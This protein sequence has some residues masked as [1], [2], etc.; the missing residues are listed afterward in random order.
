[1]GGLIIEEDTHDEEIS[2]GTSSV[3]GARR[4]SG[5]S[6]L[7]FLV[8]LPDFYLLFIV[9]AKKPSIFILYIVTNCA[10]SG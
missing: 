5:G 9:W 1:M 2:C 3:V 8:P 6:P 4:Q 7:I 10:L